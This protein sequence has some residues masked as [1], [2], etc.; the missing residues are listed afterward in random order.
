M[1]WGA[2]SVHGKTEIA[3]FEQTLDSIGYCYIVETYLLPVASL[4]YGEQYVYQ[5]DHML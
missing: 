2:F 5:Q 4:H 3:F 1:I